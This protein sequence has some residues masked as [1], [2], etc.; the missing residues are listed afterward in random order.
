VNV[1]LDR[2]FVGQLEPAALTALGGSTNIMFLMFSV[3]MALGTAATALVSR[4]FGAGRAA[5]FQ[6]ANRQTLALTVWLGLGLAFCG[7]L[8]AG[9][10]ATFLLPASDPRAI[11]LM[12][13]YLSVYAL[14]LP[15]IYIIQT[16]AGSLRG[17]GDTKSP[18]VISGL[19]IGLH[20][21][22]NFIFIFP[23]RETGVGVTI[24]GFGLGLVGAAWALTISAWCSALVYLW[25]VARTPLGTIAGMRLPNFS[26]A[27]RILRIALPA[28]GMSVLRVASLAAFTLVLKAVPN[29]SAA[30]GAMSVAFAIEAIMFMPAFGLSMAASALVG[31]S[32]GMKKPERAERLAWTAGHH[33]AA[34]IAVI[35][36]PIFFGAS[37]IAH[38]LVNGKEAMVLEAS[39][40]LRWL[41]V[42]EVLFG[43]AM[44]MTGGMQGAGDTIR[45]FWNTV[46]CMWFLRVPLAYI[47]ALPLGL[48]ATGAWIAMSFSQAVQG[49]LAI[50]MFRQG[51]WKRQVV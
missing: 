18:M 11:E 12:T 49:L 36:L 9:P 31:Q 41:C 47:L 40:L 4:A 14:G 2:G 20:I 38:V 44:V 34:V 37:G 48:G 22:L 30:I 29:A 39:S 50:W 26:W 16:L 3:A 46:I 10:S 24:P 35:S 21:L 33:G 15:A 23:P 51:A 8:M 43:Y 1:L 6:M 28:A 27:K 45:P 32:L 17:I 7:A 13:R 5:E 19:Q 42:T 25:F